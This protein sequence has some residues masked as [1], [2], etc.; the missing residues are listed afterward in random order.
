MSY[1]DTG[2]QM[3]KSLDFP[4]HPSVYYASIVSHTHTH[5]YTASQKVRERNL[6]PLEWKGSV[7]FQLKNLKINVPRFLLVCAAALQ[8]TKPPRHVCRRTGSSVAGAAFSFGEAVKK[9]YTQ[10]AFLYQ[11]IQ[12]SESILILT[13]ISCY[14]FDFIHVLIISYPAI[15]FRLINLPSF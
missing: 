12:T 3:T 1:A 11:W 6:Q 9:K 7:T 15:L 5:I 4:Q 2:L 8:T 13:F 14:W 10:S